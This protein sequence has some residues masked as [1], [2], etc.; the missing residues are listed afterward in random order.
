MGR[1]NTKKGHR[2]PETERL[3]WLCRLEQVEDEIHF[4]LTC[5]RYDSDRTP[6][7]AALKKSIPAVESM[8]PENLYVWLNTNEDST[9]GPCIPIYSKLLH[10]PRKHHENK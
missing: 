3:C 4:V 6:F 7:M 10:F 5:P 2:K 8:T 9:Y 1:Y